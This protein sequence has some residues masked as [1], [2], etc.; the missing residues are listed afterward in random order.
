MLIAMLE[1]E[2]EFGAGYKGWATD[3]D[4]PVFHLGDIDG[5]AG[6]DQR[7]DN[8]EL[9]IYIDSWS[10]ACYCYCLPQKLCCHSDP[11]AWGVT[12]AVDD[13]LV[14]Q[15]DQV[16]QRSQDG[17]GG[18]GG[19]AVEGGWWWPLG[20][21]VADWLLPLT[22]RSIIILSKIMAWPGMINRKH[23]PWKQTAL[24]I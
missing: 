21:H 8:D 23:T 7:D 5:N 9:K 16:A 20:G 17:Q 2:L 15:I 12:W 4:S 1:R 19:Q 24:P 18:Q 6:D 14:G 11:G 13:D 10:E 3:L 22:G